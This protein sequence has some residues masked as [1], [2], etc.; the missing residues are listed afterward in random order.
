[1]R[2]PVR[3]CD[4]AALRSTRPASFGFQHF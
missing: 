1:M 2:L 4:F 3:L